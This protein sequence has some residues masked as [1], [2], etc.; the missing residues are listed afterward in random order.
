MFINYYRSASIKPR[1]L[2]LDDVLQGLETSRDRSEIE[3]DVGCT[4]L[5]INMEEYLRAE[6]PVKV[7]KVH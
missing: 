2:G 1:I 7:G 4:K 5:I 6:D 3:D